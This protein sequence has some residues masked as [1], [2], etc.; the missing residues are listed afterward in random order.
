M[1][2]VKRNGKWTLFKERDGV[3]TIRERDEVRARILTPEYE[4]SGPMDPVQSDMMT[5]S[6]E[7][8]SYSE[9]EQEFLNYVE[10]GGSGGG[11]LGF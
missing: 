6:I 2:T 10:N 4:P 5:E 8:S 3:Y 9:A 11:I 1:A 7:V